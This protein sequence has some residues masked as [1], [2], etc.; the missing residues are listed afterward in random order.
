MNQSVF[1][2]KSPSLPFKLFMD[3]LAAVFPPDRGV[4]MGVDVAQHLGNGLSPRRLEPGNGVCIEG[5]GWR[6]VP[7]VGQLGAKMRSRVVFKE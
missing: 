7:V 2:S 3:C 5:R 4:C 6:G 1:L